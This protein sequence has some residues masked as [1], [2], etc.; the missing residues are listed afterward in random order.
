MHDEKNELI[1]VKLRI[2]KSQYPELYH[3]IASVDKRKRATIIKRLAETG[4]AVTSGRLAISAPIA[5]TSIKM[6]HEFVQTND[7]ET[8]TS[9]IDDF[10]ISFDPDSLTQSS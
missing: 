8:D 5:S 3:S 6:E 4:A 2:H 10:Q 9:N 7:I 1:L